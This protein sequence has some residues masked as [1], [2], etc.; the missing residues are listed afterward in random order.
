MLDLNELMGF[1]AWLFGIPERRYIPVE[2]EAEIPAR[3]RNPHP[4]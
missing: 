2:D 4:H 3:G 1:L